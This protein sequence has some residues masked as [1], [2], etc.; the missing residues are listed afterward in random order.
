MALFRHSLSPAPATVSGRLEGALS[1]VSGS[2]K[3]GKHLPLQAAPHF[4]P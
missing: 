2:G 4:W 3:E 1:R